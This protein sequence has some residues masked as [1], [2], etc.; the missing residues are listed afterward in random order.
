MFYTQYVVS[1]TGAGADSRT[2]YPNIQKK[3]ENVHNVT[4]ML[5]KVLYSCLQLYKYVINSLKF[6][7]SVDT[8]LAARSAR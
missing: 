8:S 6:Y 7:L 2:V 4:N 1:C 5:L 3:N